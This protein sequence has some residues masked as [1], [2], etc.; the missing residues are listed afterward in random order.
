MQSGPGKWFRKGLSLIDLFELFP[1]D[2]SAEKWFIEQ[3]WPHGIACPHCGCTNVQAGAKHKTMPF[4]CREC[5]KR[6]SAKTGTALEGSNIGFQKWMIGIYLLATS[7]KGVSSMKLHRDLNITQKSA[8]FMGHRLREAWERPGG[9][10]AG[11][12]EADETYIGG[13]EK[14]KHRSKKL[15]AGRGTVGKTA[16]AGVKDRVSGKIRAAVVPQTDTATLVGFVSEHAAPDAMVYTDE[17]AAYK[18]LP[19]HA[20]VKHSV[21]KYVDGMAHTNGMESFWSL[22]KRGYHGIYH[23]MSPEH[24]DRYVREFEGRH[25]QRPLDTIDQMSAI[26]RGLDGKRLRYRELIA[27]PHGCEAVAE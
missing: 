17:A 14:N 22:L 26:A 5:R 27:H 21:G 2:A 16:V 8:W 9:I 1:D 11:P 3:R 12:V 7:L 13:K 23:R 20:A 10:F 24:L 6:F 25:N 15:N 19:H 18:N 4:R